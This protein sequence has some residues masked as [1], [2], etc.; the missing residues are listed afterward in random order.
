M[1]RPG[2]RS[3]W[4]HTDFDS[5]VV[6]GGDVGLTRRIIHGYADQPDFQGG[7][8][9][10]H[11][12]RKLSGL[13]AQ[14]PFERVTVG[15]HTML[16]TDLSGPARLR[17]LST[18]ASLRQSAGGDAPSA[19]ECDAWMASLVAANRNGALLFSQTTLIVVG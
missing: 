7:H 13:V 5:V 10:P 3:V 6:A 8:A 19:E 12:G 11:M 16:A 9:D 15:A 2:G 18:V 17:I 1:T 4:S 14:S